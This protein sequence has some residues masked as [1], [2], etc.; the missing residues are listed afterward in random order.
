ME[1]C[2]GSVE[3]AASLRCVLRLNAMPMNLSKLCGLDMPN[4]YRAAPKQAYLSMKN[5]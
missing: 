3:V 4:G 1:E 2:V 5:V